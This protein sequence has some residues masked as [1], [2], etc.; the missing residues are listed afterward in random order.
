VAACN[1]SAQGTGADADQQQKIIR[2][3]TL[4]S[5]QANQEFQRNVQIMQNQRQQV[6]DLNEKLKNS[7]KA[8]EK[9]QIQK[10]LDETLKK[11]NENNQIMFKTYGFSLTRNYTL[12]VEKAHVYMFVNDE[13]AK[14]F[15]EAQAKE[16]K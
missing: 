14:K 12:V 3:S 11:L 4:N 8:D 15:E 6:I 1:L 5:I 10:D 16:Q 2:V 7:N 9:A 13:E